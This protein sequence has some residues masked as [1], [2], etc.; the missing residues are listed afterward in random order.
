[1]RSTGYG[2]KGTGDRVQSVEHH[3]LR[4][5]KRST[6]RPECRVHSSTERRVYNVQQRVESG[7]NIRA[8]Y[9]EWM[10]E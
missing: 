1:M 8:E 2:V 10:R 5:I 4:N 3:R 9:G 7:E 6:E